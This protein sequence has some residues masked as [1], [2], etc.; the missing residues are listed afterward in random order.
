MEI[1]WI[2]VAVSGSGQSSNNKYLI[3]LLLSQLNLMFILTSVSICSDLSF[4]V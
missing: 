3:K 2:N 4:S 1:K